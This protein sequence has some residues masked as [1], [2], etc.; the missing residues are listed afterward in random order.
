MEASGAVLKV[1]VLVVDVAIVFIRIAPGVIKSVL[2]LPKAVMVS[3]VGLWGMLVS[4]ATVVAGGES[5][6]LTVTA[7]VLLEEISAATV[8]VVVLAFRSVISAVAVLLA[9]KIG[10]VFKAVGGQLINGAPGAGERVC[11][12][13]SVVVVELEWVVV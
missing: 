7:G 11:G 8:V 1:V 9:E 13:V 5:I 4:I 2:L 6:V 3:A 12:V 10:V